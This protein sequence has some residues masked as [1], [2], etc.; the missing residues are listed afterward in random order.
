MNITFETQG[1]I[2]YGVYQIQPED[3]VDTLG[4]GMLTN[5]K[6]PGLAAT[7]FTQMDSQRFIKFNV[8]AKVPVSQ[9]FSGQVNRKRLV[10]VF[11]GIAAA[12]I[13]AEEYMIDANSILLDLD[14]I[15]TDVS[16]C[17][18][19]LICLP[20]Q[21]DHPP[22]NLARFFK[23]IMFNT[24]FDQ[25]ENCDYVA[26]IMNYLNSVP[27]FSLSDFNELMIS[28]EQN[29]K[30]RPAAPQVPAPQP[31]PAPQQ[32]PVQPRPQAPVQQTY[33]QPSQPAA[34]QPAQRPVP[35]Q[36]FQAPPQPVNQ[37]AAPAKGFQVPGQTPSQSGQRAVPSQGFQVPGQAPSQG[38]QVPGQ[39]PN[40]A[41]A[42]APAQET[43]GKKMSF[44]NLMM[45]YSKENAALYKAQKEAAK[46]GAPAP[47]PAAPEKP[48]KE[49]KKKG[50]EPAPQGFTVPG[51][52]SAP[53][54]GFQV[55][56]Q[57]TPPQPTNAGFTAPSQPAAPQF[58][59]PTPQQTYA[60]P[61]FQP[62]TPASQPMSFGE[63]TVLGGGVGGIG[64][65]TVL[66]ASAAGPA[67]QPKPTL[68]RAKNNER[69]SIDKPTFRI[70]KER[71]YADYFIGDNPAVSRSHA[72]IITR[73]G[74][75]YIMDTNS[76]NHT[77]V[78]GAMIPSN[79]E[80]KL[81]PGC[82]IRLGNEEFEFKI[83]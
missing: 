43:G 4:L 54:S 3:T 37:G 39:A 1:T 41:P 58:R 59:A 75:C 33:P 9:F 18:T 30:T 2:T 45:H 19:V 23:N 42:Q 83:F 31:T 35:N 11:R 26:K 65:T 78:N 22:V 25:T 53:I 28:I 67:P 24:Q 72:T 44:M 71:S 7:T 29:T 60:Q 76:T 12:L 17:E 57:T 6:I 70:G 47:Q 49:K 79:Q 34:P 20:V 62:Q 48:G 52:P 15:F 36:G 16:T 82:N 8:T 32:A 5:N 61:A 64:E 38:F 80:I 51:A 73:D 81:E 10:G 50:Q 46:S 68:I 69:I 63:T 77:Y 14:Y 21:Q 56:G 40:Q 27:N 55:P 13:S 66:G 74:T